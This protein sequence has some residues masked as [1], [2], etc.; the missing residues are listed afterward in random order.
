MLVNVNF[1][2]QPEIMSV[3]HNGHHGVYAQQLAVLMK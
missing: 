2:Y 1:F 3:I